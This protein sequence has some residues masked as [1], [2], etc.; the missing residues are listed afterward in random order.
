MSRKWLDFSIYDD[1]PDGTAVV[2]FEFEEPVYLEGYRWAT[3]ND[4]PA[5]DP[6]SWRLEGS[7]DN[8]EWDMLDE[9]EEFMATGDVDNIDDGRHEWQS[10]EE[11]DYW[12][13]S[14]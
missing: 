1:R 11:A 3:A 10:P 4:A 12:N 9:V 14:R 6:K 8:S 7:N 5:R 13:F 2:I